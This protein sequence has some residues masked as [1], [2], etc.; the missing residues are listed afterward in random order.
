MWLYSVACMAVKKAEEKTRISV[1]ADSV[2]ASH[3][4]SAEQKAKIK[5]K[6]FFPEK[7]GWGEHQVA[8][9]PV[10]KS[11]LANLVRGLII[12]VDGEMFLDTTLAPNS[13][14]ATFLNLTPGEK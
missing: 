9:E 3:A 11:D 12:N 14:K 6:A 13:D 8:V 7:E 4:Q 1:Q 10:G 5:C 2:L